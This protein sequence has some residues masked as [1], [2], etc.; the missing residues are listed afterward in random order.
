MC[1]THGG[2][3]L[4][5]S[6]PSGHDNNPQ[7]DI[8]GSYLLSEGEHWRYVGFYPYEEFRTLMVISRPL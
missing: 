5:L 8:A 7:P 2:M 1:A 3:S 4:A 6:A